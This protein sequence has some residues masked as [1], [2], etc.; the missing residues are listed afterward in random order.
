MGAMKSV[1]LA[2]CV[3]GALIVISAGCG[4]GEYDTS[5]SK[6]TPPSKEAVDE[7]FFTEMGGTL[8]GAVIGNLQSELARALATKTHV[9]A[10]ETC[11]TVAIPLTEEIAASADVSAEIKRTSMKFRNPA[12]APDEYEKEAIEYFLKSSAEG[13]MAGHYLQKV[14][15]DGGEYYRYYRPL[16]TAGK[17]LKCHGDSE[18]LAE[19]VA[20]KL[21]ETYPEDSA[22]DYQMGDF[23]GVIRVEMARK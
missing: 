15:R 7:V 16:K 6:R 21:K 20:S 3:V 23:R 8:S 1:A 9:E 10:I 18:H 2:G 14:N 19:G 12:N 22:V 5:T 11:R 4:G 17:C 13:A